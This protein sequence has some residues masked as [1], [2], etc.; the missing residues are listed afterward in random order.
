MWMG[1]IAQEVRRDHEKGRSAIDISRYV[2]LQMPMRN[3]QRLNE[4]EKAKD[5]RT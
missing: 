4:I 5:R 1:S 3:L 2:W